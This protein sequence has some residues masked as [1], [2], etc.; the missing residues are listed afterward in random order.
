MEDTNYIFDAKSYVMGARDRQGPVIKIEDEYLNKSAEG[1]TLSTMQDRADNLLSGPKSRV[2]SGAVN[3]IK[4]R[5][6][7]QEQTMQNK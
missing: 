1:K 6:F 5:N 2:S 7:A 3:T 4:N